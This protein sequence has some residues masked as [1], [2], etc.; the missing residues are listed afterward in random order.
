MDPRTLSKDEVRWIERCAMRLKRQGPLF[1]HLE[2]VG[3]AFELLC[4]WPG[5][6][7]IQAA[8]EYLAP[9]TVPGMLM[10]PA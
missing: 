3:I 4:A 8:D 1:T 9:E 7:P 6:D 2:A 5:L 10:Q